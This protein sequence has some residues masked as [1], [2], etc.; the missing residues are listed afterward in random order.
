MKFLLKDVFCI[1]FKLYQTLFCLLFTSLSP[2]L[3]TFLYI[4]CKN[5]M[6][7]Y[8]KFHMTDCNKANARAK[9]FT[10]SCQQRNFI[11]E[12]WAF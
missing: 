12:A 6:C 9:I 10:A 5:F 7:S 2:E 3:Y 8:C 4:I 11:L 1:F